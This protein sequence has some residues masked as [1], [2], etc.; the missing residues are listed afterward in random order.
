MKARIFCFAF[1]RDYT[2]SN[3]S[4]LQTTHHHS[5]HREISPAARCEHQAITIATCQLPF[6]E[7]LNGGTGQGNGAPGRIRFEIGT[8]LAPTVNALPD[9][10]LI[11]LQIYIGPTQ[12]PNLA[13]PHS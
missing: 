11:S 2:G 8:S 12:A 3:A 13:C 10:Y 4:G 5:G 6:T 9:V 7:S 1:G